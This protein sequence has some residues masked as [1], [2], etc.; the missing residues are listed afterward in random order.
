M[1]QPKFTDKRRKN[2]RR[3]NNQPTL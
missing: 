3:N 1:E 2:W